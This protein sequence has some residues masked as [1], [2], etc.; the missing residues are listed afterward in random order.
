M[1]ETIKDFLVSLG[2]K[3]DSAGLNQ[4]KSGVGT[5]TKVVTVLGAAL[6]AT[7]LAMTRFVLGT[8][9]T[10]NHLSDLSKNVGVS[11]QKIQELGYIASL[12]GSSVEAVESSLSNLSK[13]IGEASIG[14]G[15]GAATFK[16]L[17]ISAK[18]QNG[19]LKTTENLLEE[20]SEKIK[21]V[22]LSER[23]A[24]L[25]KLGVDASLG[26]ALTND[27]SELREEFTKL[28]SSI[29]INSEKAA[30]SSAGF[31]DSITRLKFVFNT[32]KSSIALQ[33]IPQ[34]RMGMDTL[35]KLMVENSK[36]IVETI[37]PILKALLKLTTAFF[38]LSKR[39][40][41]WVAT[42]VG[43]F[44]RFSGFFKGI[45]AMILA[46]VVAWRLLNTAFLASPVGRLILIGTALALLIDDFLGFQEGLKSAINWGNVFNKVLL[47]LAVSLGVFRAAMLLAI[48]G[49]PWVKAILAL[50]SL[51]MIFVD[52]WKKVQ[53][54]FKE[55]FDWM[56]TGFKKLGDVINTAVNAV[57]GKF[58]VDDTGDA[59]LS[60][61]AFAQS[62]RKLSSFGSIGSQGLMSSGASKNVTQSINQETKITVQGAESPNATAKAIATEQTRV[63]ADMTRN[64]AGA[65][66]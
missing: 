47:A 31:I 17:G 2:F 28:Y 57:K 44:N 16:Q 42:S 12:S 32:L 30:E 52:E 13:T 46:A 25:S 6:T 58:G 29:G 39:I 56:L 61:D 21:K 33:F 27:V 65:V 8:A 7:S 3:V 49:G 62:T 5:A 38:I 45:P 35:R 51:P 9:T 24:I 41:G 43:A 40:I 63:N 54:W 37:T 18:K 34:L 4:F 50:I 26:G 60:R 64:F 10:Y 14:V 55:F 22:S 15:R 48:P 20:I 19:E 59:K 36:K 11:V 66:R 1:A 23:T 53:A